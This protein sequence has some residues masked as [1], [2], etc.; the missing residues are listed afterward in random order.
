V[1]DKCDDSDFKCANG[2]CVDRR[3]VCDGEDDCGDGSDEI[4]DKG[5]DDASKARENAQDICPKKTH[6]R[7]TSDLKLCLPESAR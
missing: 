7:C 6:F 2:K 1:R 4:C 5:D 3:L